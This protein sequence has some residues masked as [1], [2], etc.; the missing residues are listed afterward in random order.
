[1]KLQHP[2]ETALSLFDGVGAEQQS[3]GV[4]VLLQELRRDI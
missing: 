4:R 2:P 3:K 1:V